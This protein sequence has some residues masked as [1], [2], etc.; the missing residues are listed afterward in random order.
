MKKE[1]IRMNIRLYKGIFVVSLSVGVLVI[2]QERVPYDGSN[3]PGGV[4]GSVPY[5]EVAIS[6]IRKWRFEQGIKIINRQ[7]IDFVKQ[8]REDE[9]VYFLHNLLDSAAII[10][11]RSRLM[12]IIECEEAGE[13]V[14][15]SRDICQQLSYVKLACWVKDVLCVL[16]RFVQK[17][18]VASWAQ[19]NPEMLREVVQEIKKSDI[20]VPEVYSQQ[21]LNTYVA[22]SGMVGIAVGS[23]I[24]VVLRGR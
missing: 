21:E 17:D 1:G 8:L 18:C 10:S 2:G 13:P 5:G 6:Q 9:K 20:V 15:S 19:Q 23:L 14:F 11:D 12:K 3:V 16:P 7:I 4:R 24:T 22:A